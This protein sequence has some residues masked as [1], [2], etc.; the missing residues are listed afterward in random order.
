MDAA[1]QH[2]IALL[3]GV[4]AEAREAIEVG[5]LDMARDQDDLD[6]PGVEYDGGPISISTPRAIGPR[7]L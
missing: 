3:Q 6:R 1:L 4:D 7:F 2:H 5:W